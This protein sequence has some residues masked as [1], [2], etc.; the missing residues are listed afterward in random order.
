LD[1]RAR[2]MQSRTRSAWATSRQRPGLR[3]LSQVPKQGGTGETNGGLVCVDDNFPRLSA[4]RCHPMAAWICCCRFS[5]RTGH[6]I[7]RL[8]ENFRAA[9][10]E[11]GVTKYDT[12]CTI[13]QRRSQIGKPVPMRRSRWA[14]TGDQA[15]PLATTLRI[16]HDWAR[17]GTVAVSR[18]K[19]RTRWI[20]MIALARG[21]IFHKI[22]TVQLFGGPLAED[23]SFHQGFRVGLDGAP[24][25][26]APGGRTAP[27]DGITNHPKPPWL[28]SRRR[29]SHGLRPAPPTVSRGRRLIHTPCQARLGHVKPSISNQP[30]ISWLQVLAI[31]RPDRAIEHN[32][33]ACMSGGRIVGHR[34][35]PTTV[36]A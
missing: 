13:P 22:S 21:A 12:V 10:P 19:S 4:V 9:Q 11:Y 27:N 17:Y 5:I 1:G 26:S 36:H 32:Q 28:S 16:G 15:A 25:A 29:E 30:P 33:H 23:D 24:G 18:Q 20:E 35:Q 8:A 6:G 14:A 3:S 34:T 31:R 2:R 7:E